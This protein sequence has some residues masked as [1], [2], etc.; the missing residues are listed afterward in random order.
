MCL[1]HLLLFFF[2]FFFWLC[3]DAFMFSGLWEDC[4]NYLINLNFE[5]V[6]VKWV[7][8]KFSHISN[9]L[10]RCVKSA[11][12]LYI[13]TKR[14]ALA[15]SVWINM[16]INISFFVASL[17]YLFNSFIC[18][19]MGYYNS[20]WYIHTTLALLHWYYIIGPA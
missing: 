18:M 10:R 17:T 20:L 6:M 16:K 2:F 7:L 15:V 5:L 14:T 13:P 4:K 8:T 3:E 11:I 19:L 12:V 9:M 1:S